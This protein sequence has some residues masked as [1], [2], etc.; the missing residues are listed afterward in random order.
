MWKCFTDFNISYDLKPQSTEAFLG[1][2]RFLRL[3]LSHEYQSPILCF[4][5][6]ILLWKCTYFEGGDRKLF[7]YYTATYSAMNTVY[8]IRFQRDEVAKPEPESLVK[9][10]AYPIQMELK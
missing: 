1:F 3:L 6:R 8:S 9:S 7:I 2:L 10:Q 5:C 4:P